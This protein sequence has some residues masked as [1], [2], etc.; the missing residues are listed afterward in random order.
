[1]RIHFEQTGGFM[2][3]KIELELDTNELSPDE[4]ETLRQVMEEANFFSLPE[5]LT[6]ESVPDGLHYLIAV[7]TENVIHSVRTSDTSAPPA[8]RPLIQNLSQ[9]ARIRRRKKDQ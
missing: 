2:G 6:T 1:M 3:L 4:I 7:E 5:D 8:L 9:Q